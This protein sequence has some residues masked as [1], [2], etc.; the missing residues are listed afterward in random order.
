MRNIHPLAHWPAE[1][2]VLATSTTASL[3]PAAT[4]RSFLLAVSLLS[5]CRQH[6]TK[7]LETSYIRALSNSDQIHHDLCPCNCCLLNGCSDEPAGVQSSRCRHLCSCQMGF[8]TR[9]PPAALSSATVPAAGRG[10][11]SW[12]LIPGAQNI[13]QP[14]IELI[15]Y[16]LLQQIR[17]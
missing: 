6:V 16:P 12:V 3:P 11:R 2:L 15:F 14:Q 13:L 7:D 8:F 10:P 4:S 1:G 9:L 17:F 5:P